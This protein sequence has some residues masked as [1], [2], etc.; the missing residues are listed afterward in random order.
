MILYM[1]LESCRGIMES[2]EGWE[3][4]SYWQSRGKGMYA[5]DVENGLSLGRAAQGQIRGPSLKVLPG[6]TQDISA[7]A[8]QT[9][10]TLPTL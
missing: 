7:G 4:S 3:S 9:T 1:K 2:R 10:A 6:I 8:G 5:D